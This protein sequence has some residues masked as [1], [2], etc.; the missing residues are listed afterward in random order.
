[1]SGFFNWVPLQCTI[2]VVLERSCY[3]FGTIS[4]W[5]SGM[6]WS[7]TWF[8]KNP[9][10][11]N[12]LKTGPKRNYH[13]FHLRIFQKMAKRNFRVEYLPEKMEFFLGIK[14]ES[15]HKWSESTLNPLKIKFHLNQLHLIGCNQLY[16]VLTSLGTLRY[17]ESIHSMR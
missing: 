8:L 12:C 7:Q 3:D 10:K 6:G 13:I 5:T 1:M 16:Q 11:L 4:R 2:S 9:K 15:N 17:L 14:S